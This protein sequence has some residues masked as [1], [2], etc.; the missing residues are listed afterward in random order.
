MALWLGA[1]EKE[2]FLEE[3]VSKLRPELNQAGV[4]GV[5]ARSAGKGENGCSSTKGLLDRLKHEKGRG[6]SGADDNQP[7][8]PLLCAECCP[9]HSPSC[10]LMLSYSSLLQ[11]VTVVVGTTINPLYR[12]VLCGLRF[13]NS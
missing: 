9:Q 11:V 5:P 1:S 4:G 7:L 13:T 6:G 12:W 3:G 2:V 10:Q 8:E